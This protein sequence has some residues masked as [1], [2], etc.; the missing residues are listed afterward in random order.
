MVAHPQF[1]PGA[2]AYDIMLL[3]LNMRLTFNEVV[4]PICLPRWVLGNSASIQLPEQEAT[5]LG[6]GILTYHSPQRS[7]Y[8]QEV[9]LSIIPRSQCLMKSRYT[10]DQLPSTLFCAGVPQGGK[11]SC[12]VSA[13]L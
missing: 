1:N 10:P 9:K 11:D 4:R 6:W 12:Q 8:L 2:Y 3:K 13:V 5:A 7:C